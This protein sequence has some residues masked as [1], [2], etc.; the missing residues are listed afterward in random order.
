MNRPGAPSE[1]ATMTSL[2]PPVLPCLDSSTLGCFY[3]STVCRTF[4]QLF[5]YFLQSIE[6]IVYC[7]PAIMTS[8]YLCLHKSVFQPFHTICLVYLQ[9]TQTSLYL[10]VLFYDL[11][12]SSDSASLFSVKV[13]TQFQSDHS[14]SDSAAAQFVEIYVKLNIKVHETASSFVIAAVFQLKT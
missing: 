3:I 6:S 5:L 4:I 12:T 14:S 13:S 1:G 2:L 7:M 10:S 11:R 8:T 9:R